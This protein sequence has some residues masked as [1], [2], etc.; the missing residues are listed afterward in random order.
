MGGS[1]FFSNGA[2]LPL[3]TQD[4]YYLV[5]RVRSQFNSSEMGVKE[6]VYLP[7][8]EQ[9][10]TFISAKL[11]NKRDFSS[12]SKAVLNARAAAQ[13]EESFS[14]FEGVWNLVLEMLRQD[15][16]FEI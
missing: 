12:F 11:L 9:G 10:M 4:F 8:D 5:E 15:P 3:S 6:K 14:R 16:R 1:I 2:Q 13:V 7:L